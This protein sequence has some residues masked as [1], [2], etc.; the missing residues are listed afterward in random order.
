MTYIF[1][2][3]LFDNHYTTLPKPISFYKRYIQ[4]NVIVVQSYYNFVLKLKIS[5]LNE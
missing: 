2:E 1:F 3:Y 5:I 4:L